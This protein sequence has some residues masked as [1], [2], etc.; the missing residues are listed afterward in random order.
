[1]KILVDADSCPVRAREIIMSSAKRLNIEA[2]FAANRSIPNI[3]GNKI[4]MEICGTGEGAAD[5]RILELAETGDLVVSRDIPLAQKLIAKDVA[6]INDRGREYNRENINE[7]LSLRNFTV[8]LANNGMDFER[9]ASYSKKEIQKF[10]A[11]LDR[12]LSK[13]SYIK[14]QKETADT[15]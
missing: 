13:L 10:A 3:K 7:S 11:S 8:G 6:V 14:L 1:M 15:H 12:I 4:R 2:V 5:Q 9:A